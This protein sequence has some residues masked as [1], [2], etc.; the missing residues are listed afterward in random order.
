MN[1]QT[2]QHVVTFQGGPMDGHTLDVTTW[3]AEQRAT[4]VAHICDRSAYGPG[5]RSWYGPL[6]G[7]PDPGASTVWV[8]EGDTP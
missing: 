2:Q 8:W 7:A 5:G 3:T 1:Q 4:G 6:E